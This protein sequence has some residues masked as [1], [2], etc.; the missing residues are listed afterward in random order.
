MPAATKG[1][2]ERLLQELAAS[3]LQSVEEIERLV[4]LATRAPDF[5]PGFTA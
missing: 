2:N 4:T 5:G 1:L 3:C